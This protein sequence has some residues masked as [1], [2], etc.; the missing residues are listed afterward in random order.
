MGIERRT[1]ETLTAWGKRPI[2]EEAEGWRR[3]ALSATVPGGEKGMSKLI[4]T[5]EKTDVEGGAWLLR[6]DQGVVYQLRGGGADLRQDGRRVEVEGEVDSASFG[7][8]MMGDVL[9]VKSHRFL[10]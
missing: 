4:G 3:T 6:T 5:V 2:A 8:A 9:E 10:D 1:A 7:I